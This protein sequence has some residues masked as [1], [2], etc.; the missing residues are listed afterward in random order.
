MRLYPGVAD[1]GKPTERAAYPYGVLPRYLLIFIT[2]AVARNDDSVLLDDGLTIDLGSSMRSFLRQLGLASTGG[3]YGSIGRLRDQVTR[4]ATSQISIISTREMGDGAWNFR[5]KNFG[6]IDEADLW[7][8]DRDYDRNT[9][10][11][12]T[13]TISP[14]FRDSIKASAVPV[15]TR[16]L[17]LIQGA[18]GGALAVDLYVWAAH[19]FY[20]LRRATTIP[21]ALLA[22]QFGS[23]YSKVSDFKASVI[24]AL[25]VVLLAYPEAKIAPSPDG[26]VLR[27]SPLPVAPS[28]RSVIEG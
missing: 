26:L 11:P 16:G 22:E 20:S 15:D 8:S 9:L 12:S 3:K 23:Q 13:I 28:K 5:S 6:M 27:P 24:K 19:R 7:W 25:P 10:W 1:P 21:W 14:A 17:A 18:K 2:T 4:L